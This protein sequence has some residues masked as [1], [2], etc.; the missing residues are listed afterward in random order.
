MFGI[1][2]EFGLKQ[3]TVQLG[4]EEVVCHS[5]VSFALVVNGDITVAIHREVLSIPSTETTPDLSVIRSRP[6]SKETIGS[7]ILVHGF[8]QN[9][10]S[11]E[12]SQRS[13]VGALVDVGFEVLNL[14]LRGHGLSKERGAKA[15]SSLDDYVDD[16]VRVVSLFEDAPFAMGHSL[17]SAVITHA[18]PKV[19][20][21]G[22][23]NIAGVHSFATNNISMQKLAS[24]GLKVQPLLKKNPL[25]LNT[26]FAG[27][28][29]GAVFPLT[30]LVSKRFPLA[31]WVPGTI[32]RSVLNERLSLGFD[33][34]HLEVWWDMSRLMQERVDEYEAVWNTVETPL[35]VLV[36]DQDMLVRPEEAARCYEVSGSVDKQ[37]VVFGPDQHESNYG[38]L[39]IMLGKHAPKHVWPVFVRWMIERL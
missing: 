14:E 5:E 3:Q 15:A 18:S 32:E 20:L 11:W 39:D 1:E 25:S 31:G 13:L 27:R 37:M 24:L 36:G 10:Y 9:R 34:L 26:G 19:A 6:A 29:I 22:I 33:W 2:R 35:L 28:L 38:H 8:S 12:V 17:G 23:V 7:V 30:E 4:S 21:K 16:F